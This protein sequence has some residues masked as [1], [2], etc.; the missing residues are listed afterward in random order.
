MDDIL[1][2]LEYTLQQSLNGY[3]YKDCLLSGTQIFFHLQ[4]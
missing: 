4:G 3:V 2:L 1:I